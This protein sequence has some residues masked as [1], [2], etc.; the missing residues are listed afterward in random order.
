M[1]P[2]SQ[3]RFKRAL[4]AGMLSLWPARA[5]HADVDQ[6]YREAVIAYAQ[7]QR[8]QAVARL[9]RYTEGY[10][11]RTVQLVASLGVVKAPGTPPPT[12]L[13]TPWLKA[14]AMLHSDRDEFEQPIEA[15]DREHPRPCPG[16]QAG[17]AARY[18]GLLAQ[19]GDGQDFARRFFL[20]QSR[21]SQRDACLSEALH[22]AREGLKLFPRDVALLLAAGNAA[23]EDAT[24]TLDYTTVTT[25]MQ[26]RYRDAVRDASARRRQEFEDARRFY[27]DALSAD[28]ASS[29]ARL[30]RGRVLWRL[31]EPGAAQAALGELP[32]VATDPDLLYLAHLFLG[33]IHEDAEHLDESAREYRAALALDPRS[34]AAAIA[35]SH[36]LRHAGETEEARSL[37]ERA[38][39]FAGK[40][41]GKDMFWEYL[42]GNSNAVDALFDAL[43]RDT[44]Q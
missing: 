10:L 26:P 7:G 29:L 20:A 37:V 40:R 27:D 34:Q 25:D 39:G 14:A 31:G 16:K 30:H 12:W 2:G 6:V 22:W 32:A 5:V 24:F 15:S 19:R 8:P 36:L 28:P 18:A 21:R 41:G 42:T 17:Y 13:D 3:A 11:A 9:S 35:L 43:R 23:E 38:L 1:V 44:L 4:A 33:R